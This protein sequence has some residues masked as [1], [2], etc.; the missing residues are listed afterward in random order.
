[1]WAAWAHGGTTAFAVRRLKIS[2]RYDCKEIS[3]VFMDVIPYAISAVCLGMIGK[4]SRA[5][6]RTTLKS[7]RLGCAVDLMFK[8]LHI[9]LK[10]QLS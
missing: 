3:R 4:L 5:L 2:Q 1:M 10:K 6:C 8:R 9:C 7:R